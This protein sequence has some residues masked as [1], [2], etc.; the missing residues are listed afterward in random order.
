MLIVL[1]ESLRDRDLRVPL[2][3]RAQD[4]L[5]NLSTA[6]YDQKH[7]V[8]G[9]R[10]IFDDLQ[11]SGLDPGPSRRFKE[12]SA[13]IADAQ[14][15][16]SKVPT[17]IQVQP[18]GHAAQV[19]LLSSAE[20]VK[21][22]VF[23]VPL[24]YFADSGRAGCS[25]LVGEDLHDIDIYVILG[26]TSAAQF[27]GFR[28]ALRR[29]DGHGGG[30][31]QTF[32]LLARQGLP[33]LCIV[34][35]DKDDPTASMGQTAA[36]AVNRHDILRALGKVAT[37]HVLPCRELENLL[38]AALVTQALPPEPRDPHR[39]KVLA[40]QHRLGTVDFAELKD[41]VKLDQVREH[42]ARLPSQER[43]R[44]CFSTDAHEALR[45]VGTLVWSFGLA[46]RGRT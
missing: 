26:E 16:R 13:Y 40:Q 19:E 25:W 36:D 12:A 33:V 37:V 24:D 8:T 14:A 28:C 23:N 21:Q 7:L 3:S 32:E 44:L 41:L 30:T 10:R 42:L 1:S 39:L 20:A 38:P 2:S 45:E 29:A 46:R 31:P 5:V 35:S 6:A 22:V 11:K 15:L 34:D 43:A 17:Y 9:S 18:V 27:R 4:A